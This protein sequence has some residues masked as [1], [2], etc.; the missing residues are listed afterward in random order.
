MLPR[1]FRPQR[2]IPGTTEN[3][4]HEGQR[5]GNRASHLKQRDPTLKS[6]LTCKNP[7]RLLRAHK[8]TTAPSSPPEF[9][10]RRRTLTTKNNAAATIP[11]DAPTY[12]L[13]PIHAAAPARGDVEQGIEARKKPQS[14][15]RT[16]AGAPSVRVTRSQAGA[17]PTRIPAGKK[18]GPTD[19]SDSPLIRPCKEGASSCHTKVSTPSTARLGESLAPTA[20]PYTSPTHN[21]EDLER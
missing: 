5:R 14:G 18:Q 19:T 6:G 10:G 4:F 20:I 1:L 11:S 13:A 3:P 7:T 8:G 9:W 12:P 17:R 21:S 15:I 2:T 16:R